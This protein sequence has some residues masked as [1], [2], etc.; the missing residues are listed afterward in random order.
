LHAGLRDHFRVQHRR[1][2]D[3]GLGVVFAE[4]VRD[5]DE[6][7]RVGEDRFDLR[8]EHARQL[9]DLLEGERER[10]AR[11]QAG[12]DVPRPDGAAVTLHDLLHVLVRH[13]AAACRSRVPR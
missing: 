6:R 13:L 11:V 12:D 7:F 8:D 9:D 10:G 1:H 4:G 5:R 3:A 2:A